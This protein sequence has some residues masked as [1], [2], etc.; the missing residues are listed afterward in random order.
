MSRVEQ[1]HQELEQLKPISVALQRRWE[2]QLM[3][4]FNYNSNRIEGNTLTYGQTQLL[5]MFGKT[6]GNADMRDLEEMKA[7]N[8]GLKMIKQ[9]ASDKERPLTT[10]FIRELNG[11]ILKE[12]FWKNAIAQDGQPTR[13]KVKVGVYKTRPNSVVTSTGALF[14]YASPEETSALMSDLAAWYNSAEKTALL[15]PIELASLLHYRYIRIHP[16]EDGNGRIARL[17]VSYVLEKHD[18]PMVIVPATE[19]NNYIDA[20]NLCD[21]NTGSAPADGAAATLEQIKPFLEYMTGLLEKTLEH[22]IQS[23][24]ESRPQST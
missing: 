8:A 2:Q 7:H 20:L 23:V 10:A 1:L 22:Y 3:V 4:D 12:D 17:L 6:T 21:I 24:K 18:Y 15:S 5:L 9:Y 16:F 14:E 19:R 11:I 13:M